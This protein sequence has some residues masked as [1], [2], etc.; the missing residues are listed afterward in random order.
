MGMVFSYILQVSLIMSILYICYKAL[1]SS[2][3]FHT[4][5]RFILVAI[6][7]ISWLLPMF[8]QEGVAE[9]AVFDDA[10]LYTTA[11]TNINP[12][13]E[14]GAPIQ[15]KVE[16]SA[17]LSPWWRHVSV[18][19]VFGVCV[20]FG[21]LLLSVIKL[22]KVIATGRHE[23]R[24]GYT[25]VIS[26]AV[27]G[28]LSWGRYIVLRP[29]DMDNNLS[30][31]LAH[32]LRH[33]RRLHWVDNLLFQINRVLMW[34]NPI[35]YFAVSELKSI[36]EYEADD[37]IDAC[38][39]HD[40]QLMLIKKTVGT[41]FPTLANSLN[42]SQI[43]KRITMMMK[44]KSKGSRRL[45]ALALP[46]AALMGMMLLSMPSVASVMNNLRSEPVDALSQHKIS[47]NQS[48]EQISEVIDMLNTTSEAAER[49]DDA[50][51]EYGNLTSD[52]SAIEM[53]DSQQTTEQ[54]PNQTQPAYFVNGELYTKSINELA[55]GDIESMTIVKDDPEYPNGKIM[56]EL[57]NE[58]KPFT[59]VEKMAEFEGGQAA[60]FSWLK[61]NIRY[62]EEAAENNIQGR[63]IVQFVINNASSG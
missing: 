7:F 26:D 56:I 10:A 63:V 1:L 18:I 42:H 35:A 36:H 24:D 55:P 11:G 48:N 12:T 61:N 17:P 60:L 59:A 50:V 45:A 23:G 15:V 3:T 6:L 58:E 44:S 33:V 16:E 39:S 57:K 51:V 8:V 38:Q 19:Y 30:M 5:K 25:E 46:G 31:V 28:P 37:A 43:Y 20:A 29:Q 13:I 53:T 40:Y 47:Q 9:Y 27:A 4:F 34:F 21:L 2:A 22:C 62:P 14:I 49:A 41:G 32:E 52:E 54:S